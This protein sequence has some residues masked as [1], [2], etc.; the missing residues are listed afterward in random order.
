MREEGRAKG[1]NPHAPRN[2]KPYDEETW[3]HPTPEAY[4]TSAT[5]VEPVLKM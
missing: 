2:D 5:K 3:L 4:Y 1:A